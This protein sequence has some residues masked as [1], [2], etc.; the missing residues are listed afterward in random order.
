[1]DGAGEFV[2][3][4][5]ETMQTSKIDPT[6]IT[7]ESTTDSY[8]LTGGTFSLSQIDDS[9]TLKIVPSKTDLDNLKKKTGLAVSAATSKVT[10]TALAF[11]DMNNQAVNTVQASACD[12]FSED[13][14]RP[15]LVDFDFD[16]N[17]QDSTAELVLYFSE[18][19]NV[20]GTFDYTRIIIQDAELATTGDLGANKVSITSGGNNGFG[21]NDVTAGSFD[22]DFNTFGESVYTDRIT[23]TV[24]AFDANKLKQYIEVATNVL[25]AWSMDM[26]KGQLSCTFTETVTRDSFDVTQF[27]LQSASDSATVSVEITGTKH[28]SGHQHGIDVPHATV[29]GGVDELQGGVTSKGYGQVIVVTLTIEDLNEVKRKSLC[30]N[31]DG[32]NC[33]VTITATALTDVATLANVAITSTSALAAQS[34]VED[35]T[36]PKLAQFHSFNAI[37]GEIRVHFDEPMK[38]SSFMAQGFS[39]ALDDYHRDRSTDSTPVPLVSVSITSAT[40]STGQTDST[41][42]SF[43]LTSTELN[44]VKFQDTLAVDRGSTVFIRFNS[45]FMT[46]MAGNAVTAVV[47]GVLSESEFARNYVKDTA[48]PVLQ[49]FSVNLDTYR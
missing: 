20:P 26:D 10:F 14:T 16:A 32:S 9:T 28:T 5:D 8:A 18:T 43:T 48:P 41:D 31:T 46:D 12:S 45:A 49:E 4:F 40:F 17:A 34:L 15:S 38:L 39:L 25:Q 27:S 30:T 24:T 29:Y 37:T 13:K 21:R 6:K 23:V 33:F 1:M 42:I 2:F 36:A 22:R 3:V 47:S 11:S 7:I 35:K 44:A 19:M